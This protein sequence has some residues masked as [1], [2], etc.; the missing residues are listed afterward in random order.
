[1][2]KIIFL[3]GSLLCFV[4]A[5]TTFIKGFSTLSVEEVSTKL[6]DILKSK[7]LRIFGVFEHSKLAKEANL[8]MQDTIVVAFGAPKAGTP[9]MQCAP[10]IALELPLKI[11]IY[12]DKDGKTN[13]LYRDIKDIAKDYNVDCK[14]VLDG[15]S[16]AQAS[17]FEA[18]TD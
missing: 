2:K 17:F 9:L 5:E 1:M 4:S 13:I 16:K 18:I 11:L 3:L 6:Q 7:G 10:E 14:E 8:S 12:K 15:L